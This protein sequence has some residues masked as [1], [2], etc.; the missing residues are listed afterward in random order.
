MKAILC[1]PSRASVVLALLL[2]GSLLLFVIHLLR[3]LQ[4]PCS[5]PE[6]MRTVCGVMLEQ[7]RRRREPRAGE[8]V[9]FLYGLLRLAGLH[10]DGACCVLHACVVWVGVRGLWRESDH[11]D[12]KEPCQKIVAENSTKAFTITQEPLSSAADADAARDTPAPAAGASAAGSEDG[13]KKEAGGDAAAVQ[14]ATDGTPVRVVSKVVGAKGYST[15]RSCF[16]L[17]T[18]ACYCE[19]EICEPERTA[20]PSA[21]AAHCR[22]GFSTARGDIEAPVGYDWFGF[23]YRDLDGS[24]F[25]QSVR[26]PF[27][28]SYG[29]GDVVGML[30]RLPELPEPADGVW[31]L[32][33]DKTYRLDEK[34]VPTKKYL[35]HTLPG[36]RATN[37]TPT[38]EWLQVHPGSSI[39]FFVNGKSQ[40]VAFTDI[41]QGTYYP[42]VSLYM[43]ATVRVHFGPDDFK[44]ATKEELEAKGITPAGLLHPPPRINP[45]PIVDGNVTQD[46]TAATTPA[47]ATPV[48]ATTAMPTT[49]TTTVTATTE[50]STEPKR[51]TDQPSET[52]IATSTASSTEIN[53]AAAATTTTV[54]PTTVD[55]RRD[56]DVDD[57]DSSMSDGADDVEDG[58]Q[59]LLNMAP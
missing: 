37:R 8:P 7:Q 59:A 30:I 32:P 42:A 54:A 35:T 17:T 43:G 53:P 15:A 31:A 11:R 28:S 13:S 55:N 1:H 18:G 49:T 38:V 27:G 16:G 24:V 52:S 6:V 45:V 29:V 2:T 9:Y 10:G 56:G 20:I 14:G 44:Y 36:S 23:C 3:I 12:S 46:S 26:K 51:K 39:E 41:P 25:H 33:Q 50:T 21:P 4:C 5:P 34:F 47:E 48:A 22:L 58:A 40:G 57:D 19:V